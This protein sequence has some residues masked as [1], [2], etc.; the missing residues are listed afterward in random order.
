[1]IYCKLFNIFSYHSCFKCQS[2]EQRLTT[3]KKKQIE[4]SKGK[5][6]RKLS[7]GHHHIEW[8]IQVQL[9]VVFGKDPYNAFVLPKNKNSS[10]KER[11]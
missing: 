8:C 6:Y 10:I 1:L 5:A 3:R 11:K 2:K 7:R 9:H 4:R